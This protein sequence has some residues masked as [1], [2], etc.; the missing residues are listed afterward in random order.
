MEFRLLNQNLFRLVRAL[1]PLLHW[2]W[3][4]EATFVQQLDA[5]T[6]LKMRTNLYDR[7]A[8]YEVWGRLEYKDKQFVI[9][10]GDVVVDIGAHIGAFSVWAA[11]QAPLG[12]VY[13]FEPNG[14]NHA[15]LVE[16]KNINN[17]NNLEAFNI[18]VSDRDGEASFLIRIIQACHIPS[19]SLARR[20]R[21]RSARF[22]WRGSWQRIRLTG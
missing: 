21:S 11:C 20:I 17:L 8:V 12:R 18:A 10:P 15:L 4:G 9:A 6:K 14:E 1:A 22:L 16:N 2:R 19:L 5:Q 13:A 7:W 3:A